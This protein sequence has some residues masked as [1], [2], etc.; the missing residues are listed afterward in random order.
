MKGKSYVCL[1]VILMRVGCQ[2][3]FFITTLLLLFLLKYIDL[4]MKIAI[5]AGMAIKISKDR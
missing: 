4:A 1:F 5:A 2:L 3:L